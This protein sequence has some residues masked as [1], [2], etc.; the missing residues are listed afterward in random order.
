MSLSKKLTISS[1]LL[2]IAL[3]SFL[4]SMGCF[5]QVRETIYAS[6]YHFRPN[7]KHLT[8]L[9][10]KKELF[11][12]CLITTNTTTLGK[13]YVRT[14]GPYNVVSLK[15][16]KILHKEGHIITQDK[17]LLLD[18]L[19]WGPD[20]ENLPLFKKN[21]YQPIQKLPY[22]VAVI[23]GRSSRSY[24][25]WMVDQLPRLKLLADSGLS[26]DKLFFPKITDSFQRETLEILGI[27]KENIIESSSNQV[28]APETTIA[29]SNPSTAYINNDKYNRSNHFP[30]WVI[31][32]L[33]ENFL[34]KKADEK[35]P[36]RKVYITRKNATWR[37]ILNEMEIIPK[38]EEM[39]FEIHA[40]EKESIASQAKLFNES[41]VIIGPHGAAFTNLVFCQKGCK[42]I[43]IFNPKH[44][45][46]LFHE[47]SQYMDLDYNL[48]V[49]SSALD[50]QDPVEEKLDIKIDQ[51]DFF[52]IINSL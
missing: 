1:L 46:V 48:I 4:Y 44:P 36:F 42:V 10:E 28:F 30:R 2:I 43:E 15:K 45:E 34:N 3:L 27:K 24:Y 40:L 38:L 5:L 23:S 47:L 35:A 9:K 16:A 51:K 14:F 50:P 39:G 26:Y 19:S 17:Q 21:F 32:F 25:H 31:P 8:P 7:E 29:I 18:S 13:P 6:E 37:R 22:T 20:L 11:P 49:G 41:K 52:R 12:T 33:R